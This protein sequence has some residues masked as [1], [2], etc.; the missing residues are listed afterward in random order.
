MPMQ[1][2]SFLG[3]ELDSVS[4]TARLTQ[5]NAQSVL[6]CLKILSGTMAVSLKLFQRLLWHMAAATAIVLLHMRPPQ[7]WLYGRVQRWVWQHGTHWVQITPARSLSLWKHYSWLHWP[8]SRDSVTCRHFRSMYHALGLGGWLPVQHWDPGP[9]YMPKVPTMP[10]G[11]PGS[12]PASATPGGV[13]PSPSFALSCTC[14][15]TVRG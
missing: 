1:M 3:M 14:T 15:K 9:A 4:Q 7:H 12:E 11:G 2:I 8:R 10:F 5:K 6:I 13:R